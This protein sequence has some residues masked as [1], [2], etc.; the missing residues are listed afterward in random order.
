MA[1]LSESLK[2][3]A[4]EI[5]QD[6]LPTKS[7]IRYNEEYMKFFNWLK[8]ENVQP[9]DVTDEVLLVYLSVLAKNNKPSTLWCKYSMIRSCLS[10]KENIDVSQ[11]PKSV[12][13]LK[14]Q[15]VGYKPKKSNVLTADEVSTFIVNAHDKEWLL[16]KIVLVFGIFGAC[17]RDDLLNL[18]VDDVKD[19]GSFFTVFLRE[20]KTHSTRSFTITDEG[21]T[22]NPCTLIRKYMNMRPPNMTSDRFFVAYKQGKCVAQNFGKNSIAAVPMKVA[23]FLRLENPKSYT[24]HALRRTSASMLVEGGGDLLTLKRHGG[25]KSSTV[26]EGYIEDSIAKKLEVSNKLF[27]KVNRPSSSTSKPSVESEKQETDHNEPFFTIDDIL[28]KD[29]QEEN[30]NLQTVNNPCKTQNINLTATKNQLV[31]SSRAIM[32]SN[33]KNCTFNIYVNSKPPQ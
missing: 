8:S 19:N 15:S 33:N 16:N 18:K 29:S 5:T 22:F 23:E 4:K 3:K 30:V 25:W 6:L 17:R 9:C 7:R 1:N 26:A 31:E 10:V 2:R 24:G 32:F 11:F 12:A 13:F 20:G 14:R 21:C 27:S 28:D